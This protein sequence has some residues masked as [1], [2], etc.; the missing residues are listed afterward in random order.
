MLCDYH[1]VLWPTKGDAVIYSGRP[2]HWIVIERISWFNPLCSL[3]RASVTHA[4][5]DITAQANVDTYARSHA[6][7][8][9]P[10]LS[11]L[12]QRVLERTNAFRKQAG[13]PVV[14]IGYNKA[15]Q[16]HAEAALEG[17][18]SSHWDRWGLTPNAR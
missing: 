17:C 6:Y 18:Y 8:S 16:L 1:Q 11:D 13:V 14:A 10:S 3:L 9:T 15:A 12:K 7:T 5:A 2:G 4:G